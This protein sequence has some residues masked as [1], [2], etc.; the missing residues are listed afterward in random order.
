MGRDLI[1]K[2]LKQTFKV[3]LVFKKEASNLFK[4]A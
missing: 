3:C 2:I 1:G 4:L